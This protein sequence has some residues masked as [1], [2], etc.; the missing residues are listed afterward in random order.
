MSIPGSE[1]RVG[2]K[3]SG[4][5]GWLEVLEVIHDHAG[6]Q[7]LLEGGRRVTLRSGV[8]GAGHYHVLRPNL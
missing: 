1:V 4:V 3:L 6:A 2:D 8:P 7:V 5:G